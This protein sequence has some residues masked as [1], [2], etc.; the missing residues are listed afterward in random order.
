VNP[1][2]LFLLARVS[3]PDAGVSFQPPAGWSEDP[4]LA[5]QVGRTFT[6]EAELVGAPTIKLRTGARAWTSPAEAAEKGVVHLLWMVAEEASPDIPATVRAQLDDAR[7]RPR[8]TTIPGRSFELVSWNEQVEG[9]L[10]WGE[11]EW[12]HLENE[13]RTLARTTLFVDA[14]GRVHEIRVECVMADGAG[15][16]IAGDRLAP[17]TGCE[18]AMKGVAP[19]AEAALKSLGDVP[20][21]GALK[22]TG[23]ALVDEPVRVDGGLELRTPT[24][25]ASVM[26]STPPHIVEKPEPAENQRF[27]RMLLVGGGAVVILALAFTMGRKRKPE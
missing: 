12:R 21:Q 17:R 25:G 4:T 6:T 1:L 7:Q 5:R 23:D 26:P 11:I 18:A 22:V 10:A 3:L 13:T 20:G 14:A 2:V 19:L 27:S 9:K 16:V 24:P 8:L 15:A